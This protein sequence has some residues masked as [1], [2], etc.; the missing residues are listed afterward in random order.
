VA[1]LVVPRV[2]DDLRYEVNLSRYVVCLVTIDD[3]VKAGDIARHLV[4]ERLAA[5]V[6]IIP[7]I[8]SIYLWKGQV[9]DDK[10]R[11]LIIK[12]RQDLFDKL[13]TAIRALHPYEV[14]EI[15]ALNVEKGLPEYLRWIDDCTTA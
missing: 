9:C 6:N 11:L 10:E 12:T 13:M 7:E 4:E 8:R 5:C 14:P 15:I 1:D 2:T 3:P